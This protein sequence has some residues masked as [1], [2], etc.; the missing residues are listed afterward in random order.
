MFDFNQKAESDVN[1]YV[2]HIKNRAVTLINNLKDKGKIKKMSFLSN[3]KEDNYDVMNALASAVE[4]Q[5]NAKLKGQ[6]EIFHVSDSG[7]I[8]KTLGVSFTYN[9][10]EQEK[11]STSGRQKTDEDLMAIL[12]MTP[13]EQALEAAKLCEAD[14]KRFEELR[15][16]HQA[17]HRTQKYQNQAGQPNAGNTAAASNAAP[18]AEESSDVQSLKSEIQDLETNITILD[19]K[20]RKNAKFVTST[21][22]DK[23]DRATKNIPALNETIKALKIQKQQKE[24]ELAELQ[25]PSVEPTNSVDGYE[26]L[27]E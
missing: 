23:R 16:H 21:D 19:E 8:H 26:S 6:P 10:A 27:E 2:Q 20:V 25:T 14:K 4:T 11:T 1:M 17:A 5:E 3:T 24:T 13:A 12:G 15:K 18:T 7:D 22:Q 9:K